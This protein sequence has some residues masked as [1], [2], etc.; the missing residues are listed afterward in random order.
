M[1]S[2][3]QASTRISSRAKTKNKLMNKKAD[4]VTSFDILNQFNSLSFLRISFSLS[5]FY[6]FLVASREGSCFLNSRLF[7]GNVYKVINKK[8]FSFT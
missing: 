3:F 4:C 2:I 8:L 7:I 6:T 1:V 5:L